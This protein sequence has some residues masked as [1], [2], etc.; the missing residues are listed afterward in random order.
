MLQIAMSSF[1]PIAA[2]L[3]QI[4]SPRSCI[5]VAALLFS[6]GGIITSQAP[7]IEVFLFGRVVSGSGAA[8]IMT[9][10]F[11]LVLELSGKKRRG[12]FIGL[13]NT[14]FTIGVSLGAVIVGALLQVRGWR[15]L[16][17]IQ[18]PLGMLAGIGLFLSI[19]SSF[20]NGQKSDENTSVWSK[21]AKIDYLGALT[22]VCICT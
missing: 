11:I 10:S 17:W 12:L 14:G 6:I 5:F 9:I 7:S 4:F 8:G 20:T 21:L 15:F 1:S 13:I 2:R 19:P 22:L 3:A 18:A 16:F